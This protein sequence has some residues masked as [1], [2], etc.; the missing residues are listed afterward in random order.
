MRHT[1]DNKRKPTMANE[2]YKKTFAV[3][4]DVAFEVSHVSQEVWERYCFRYGLE[5][6]EPEFAVEAQNALLQKVLADPE[7][8]ELLLRHCLIDTGLMET[9][10]FHLESKDYVPKEFETSQALA[11]PEHRAFFKGSK[12]N[13]TYY[14][15]RGGIAKGCLLRLEDMRI[16]L[17]HEP[18]TL[19][20]CGSL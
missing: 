12:D 6:P 2:A 8:V 20:R 1:V 15:A 16:K 18:H 7:K 11:N 4:L 5:G 14:D 19:A 3:T 13:G 10:G 9:S 17:L